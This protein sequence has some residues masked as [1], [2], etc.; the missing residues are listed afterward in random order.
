MPQRI[1]VAWLFI[2]FIV[3]LPA[4]VY[5]YETGKAIPLSKPG[6]IIWNNG[7]FQGY[8]SSFGTMAVLENPTNPKSKL[9]N[10]PII[11]IHC[12]QP[13]S[14]LEPF[15]LFH[16][17][18]GESNI[19]EYLVFA[20][21]LKKHDLIIVGYRGVDGS[22]VLEEPYYKKALTCDTL[23]I[24]NQ[25]QIF[26]QASM[27]A[28]KYLHEKN[29]EWEGYNLDAMVSDIEL[30]RIH[31]GYQ[32][33]SFF[34]FSFGTMV[35]QLY[36]ETFPD[37]VQRNILIG[38]RPIGNF[39]FLDSIFEKKM[40]ELFVN[41]K[42]RKNESD[43]LKSDL[44]YMLSQVIDSN[45]LIE[46]KMNPVLFNLFF[47]SQFYSYDNVNPFFEILSKKNYTEILKKYEEFYKNYPNIIL[48]DMLV[49]KIKWNQPKEIIEKEQN[50]I[51]KQIIES[52]NDWYYPQYIHQSYKK[53]AFQSGYPNQNTYYI[54]G[55]YDVASPY[56]LFQFENNTLN[57]SQVI[58]MPECSHLDLFNSKKEL[59]LN[60]IIKK[61][62]KD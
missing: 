26:V 56:E 38:A 59:L 62:E 24:N 21:I 60:L 6:Q 44:K 49:K 10:I 47:F 25:N 53:D 35:A 28:L 30:F 36:S 17:G 50:V 27:N 11:K 12:L 34:A 43:T 32:K 23:C 29:I 19:K 31:E 22:V 58:L 55:E 39:T 40:F 33:I 14:V 8:S 5:H 54:F 18:P 46:N 52:L 3:E 45:N 1:L 37:F 4:Q 2:L 57:D 13:D 42:I 61:M 48:G 15:L 51:L 7:V 9:I 41:Y 20:E 16:G